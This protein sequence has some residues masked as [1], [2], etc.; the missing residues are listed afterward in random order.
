MKI[1]STFII[2]FICLH[3]NAQMTIQQA[4]ELSNSYQLGSY[5]Y[6]QQFI[7]FKNYGAPLI[8]T[9]DG[10]MAVYGD[11]EVDGKACGVLVKTDKNGKEQWKKSIV[12]QFDELESQSVVE[13]STGNFLVFMLSYD[14]TRYRGGSQRVICYDKNGKQLWDKTLGKYTLA[15]NPTISYI[16]ALPDGRIALRG[17]IVLKEAVEGNDPVYNYWEGWLDGTG[18]LTQKT[19]KVLDWSDKS[20]EDLYKPE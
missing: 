8:L 13:S 18:K 6:H 5:S 3:S 12:K 20:W 14:H 4:R 7:G 2:A 11:G 10:G 1:I 15:N 9:K 17:H 16:K 19:G